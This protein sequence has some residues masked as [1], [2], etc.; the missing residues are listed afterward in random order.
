MSEKLPELMAYDATD[1]SY[2]SIVRQASD[3]AGW[4]LMPYDNEGYAIDDLDSVK[5]SAVVAILGRNSFAYASFEGRHLIDDS[6][7]QSVPLSVIADS[8]MESKLIL[9]KKDLFIPKSSREVVNTLTNWLIS[10]GSKAE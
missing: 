10:L 3:D 7:T 6:I 4:R 8:N 1:N 2:L 9:P 5:P